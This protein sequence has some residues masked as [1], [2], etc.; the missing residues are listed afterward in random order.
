[1]KEGK[2]EFKKELSEKIT[3]KDPCELVRHTGVIQAPRDVILNIK[4]V[5]Y[6]ELISN[7][8]NALCCGGGGLLKINNRL[9]DE[10]A[11]SEADIVVNNCPLCLDTISLGVKKK[12]LNVEV[13]DMTELVARAMGIKEKEEDK[14]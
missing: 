5:R 12:N 10:I 7:K 9:M 13:I 1:M 14:D 6:E 4:N 2:I 3:Y 8:E 11:Y